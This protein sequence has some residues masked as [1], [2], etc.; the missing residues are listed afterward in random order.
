MGGDTMTETR[1]NI[2]SVAEPKDGFWLSLGGLIVLLVTVFVVWLLYGLAAYN[3]PKSLEKSGQ[4]GD[5]FGG[6]TALFS[7]LAFAGLV[8]TLFVQKKELQYQREELGHLVEEQRQTKGH[9]KD[10]ATH[11]KSQSEFIERPIFENNFFQLLSSFND[12]VANTRVTASKTVLEGHDAYGQIF[13]KL[14]LNLFGYMGMREPRSAIFRDEYEIFYQGNKDDLGP[15]YRQLYNILK[16][17]RNSNLE[18]QKF[19]S[20]IV[21]AQISSSE[22]T[23]LACNIASPHGSKKM[24]PL[25]KEFEF[26]KYCDDAIFFKDDGWDT[27]LDEF[28]SGWA[29]Y[30]RLESDP[31][32]QG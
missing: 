26:L 22:L 1:P 24:A 19:Y 27:H 11:L 2:G 21:R 31:L 7:G 23:L 13:A 17:I 15:Y 30:E 6:I 4:T 14:K 29:F 12:Y 10:Q 25:I 9:L 28:F 5:M 3:F 8:F 32:L 18:D 20:N 16:F